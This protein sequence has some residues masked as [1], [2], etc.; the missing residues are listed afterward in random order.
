MATGS[1]RCPCSPAEVLR[2]PG[3]G[4]RSEGSGVAWRGRAWAWACVGVAQPSADLPDVEPEERRGPRRGADPPLVGWAGPTRGRGS[5]VRAR[6]RDVRWTKPRLW[7]RRRRRIGP[8]AGREATL[9]HVTRPRAGRRVAAR[10]PGGPGL[11]SKGVGGRRRGPTIGGFA[12]CRAGGTRWAATRGKSAS[13]GVGRAD[14]WS[15]F[16]GLG[17]DVAGPLATTSRSGGEAGSSERPSAPEV[18]DRDSAFLLPGGCSPRL[19]PSGGRVH[20][21]EPR[22]RPWAGRGL[23]ATWRRNPEKPVAER[24][25]RRHRCHTPSVHLF[26]WMARW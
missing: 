18:L 25:S 17:A 9:P 5:R 24:S 12:R 16:A 15:G 6:G 1:S 7:L 23:A 11:S 4:G 21:T 2:A 26:P 8:L 19:G 13:G 20:W 14:T 22:V 3:P 10:A